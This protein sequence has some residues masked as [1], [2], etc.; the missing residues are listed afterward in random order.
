M[1]PKLIESVQVIDGSV[2]EEHT[3]DGLP[4]RLK[5][6]KIYAHFGAENVLM[7]NSPGAEIHNI[8]NFG[9]LS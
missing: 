7:K 2:Y 3:G 1:D 5:Q 6:R 4:R 9:S 8:V